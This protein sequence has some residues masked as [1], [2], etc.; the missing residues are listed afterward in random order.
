MKG[1]H[2]SQ[3]RDLGANERWK[4]ISSVNTTLSFKNSS[5]LLVIEFLVGNTPTNVF[6]CVILVILRHRGVLRKYYYFYLK[7]LFI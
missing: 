4:K 3:S 2:A 5:S 6:V 1:Q 7:F